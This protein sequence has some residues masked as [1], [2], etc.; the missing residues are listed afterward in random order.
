MKL[1]QPYVSLF[2]LLP[3]ILPDIIWKSKSTLF[4]F[5]VTIDISLIV[6]FNVCYTW[7]FR[8]IFMRIFCLWEKHFNIFNFPL[9]LSCFMRQLLNAFLSFISEKWFASIH[10]H[11][12]RFEGMNPTQNSFAMT[13]VSS[14]PQCLFQFAFF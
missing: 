11:L 5:Y 12:R 7:L 10:F 3:F 1:I 8:W 14:I 9:K 2:L 4:N 13:F 6:Q